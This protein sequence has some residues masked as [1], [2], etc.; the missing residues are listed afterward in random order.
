MIGQWQKGQWQSNLRLRRSLFVLLNA[1]ALG[2][3]LCLFAWPIQAFFADRDIEI[4]QQRAI[5]ARLSAIAAQRATVADLVTQAASNGSAE[6]LQG[7]NDGVAAA[8]L[9]TLVKGMVELTG[10]RLRSVRTLPTK[11]QEDMKIIGVQVDITGTIQAVYQSVRAVE[12]A[13]PF[14]FIVGALLRP[15]QRV[16][17]TPP[18]MSAEPTIDAQLD[19][20]G[21]MQIEGDK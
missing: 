12:T 10:A 14:L 9:Q 3:L 19:I 2:G 5:L 11:P 17:M 20:V 6:F 4:L 18:G 1:A 7:G 15:T 21:A 8:N 16:A 13:K